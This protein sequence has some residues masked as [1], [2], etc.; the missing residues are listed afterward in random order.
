[1]KYLLLCI[2][3][4]ISCSKQTSSETANENIYTEKETE[5]NNI[6]NTNSLP[7][8]KIDSVYVSN[9]IFQ[10][11]YNENYEQPNWVKYTVRDIVKNADRDGM[12][13]YT[14]DSIHTSDYDDYYSNRWDRGHMAPAGSFNDSYENLYATFSYLNVALQYDDLNRGAWVDLEVLDTGA[15]VPTAFFK[16]VIFPDDSMKC[17]YFPNTTPDKTWEEY[18][19]ECN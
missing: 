5:A 9:N 7:R 4:L 18:E 12:Q 11:S 14:V 10:I 19:I 8:A 15:H 13:F 3:F 2:F 17:Y 6:P 16:H 1:M